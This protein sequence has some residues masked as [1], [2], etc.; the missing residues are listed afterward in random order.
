MATLSNAR[1]VT[2][3]GTDCIVTSVTLSPVWHYHRCHIITGVTLSP[4]WHCHRCD[5]VIG[6][7]LS[8]LWH[9][10]R[11]DIVTGVT[12]SPVSHCHRCHIVAGVIV[13]V[14]ASLYTSRCDKAPP[15]TVLWRHYDV[16]RNPDQPEGIFSGHAGLE[17]NH[18][19]CRW[20]SSRSDPSAVWK[21]N[22]H[23]TVVRSVFTAFVPV[24]FLYVFNVEA[25]SPSIYGC[26]STVTAVSKCRIWS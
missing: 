16:T 23:A 24:S 10:H 26:R 21:C 12:L 18:L 11:C 13:S 14:I 4:L 3:T 25:V 7:T 9:C 19:V 2:A 1:A 17:K 20:K 15:R 6:V 8:P 22:I 5:I